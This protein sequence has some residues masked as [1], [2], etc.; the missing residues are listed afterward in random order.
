[1]GKIYKTKIKNRKEE[2]GPIKVDLLN[3]VFKE[4]YLEKQIINF[5]HFQIKNKQHIKEVEELGWGP[6]INRQGNEIISLSTLNFPIID[7]NLSKEL[8]NEL[9]KSY[10]FLKN[11]YEGKNGE[12]I[13][14]KDIKSDIDLL[15]DNFYSTKALLYD[16]SIIQN[17]PNGVHDNTE[18]TINTDVIK[19]SNLYDYLTRYYDEGT[20]LI[21]KGNFIKRV[22][23]KT[24]SSQYFYGAF[25]AIITA[26]ATAY[27]SH[28]L[29]LSN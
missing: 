17:T 2:L 18:I 12:I 11:L 23:Q 8:M 6:E 27:F 5:N 26:A 19:F 29:G 15:N 9:N 10:L 4:L 7:T 1:M 16:S 21:K 25:I 28:M 14:Y 24:I 13:F 3:Q 22:F 20:W